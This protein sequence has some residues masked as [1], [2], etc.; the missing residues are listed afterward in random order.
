VP[1]V[2]HLCNSATFFTNTSVNRPIGRQVLGEIR[3]DQHSAAAT[4]PE[5][6]LKRPFQRFRAPAALL[7]YRARRLALYEAET[8]LQIFLVITK[9]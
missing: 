4:K 2:I 6:D 3:E 7:P 8:G 1:Q 9:H 5:F